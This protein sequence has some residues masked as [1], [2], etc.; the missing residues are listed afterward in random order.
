MRSGYETSFGVQHLGC[1]NCRFVALCMH[2]PGDRAASGVSLG[3]GDR[4]TSNKITV[5]PASAYAIAIVCAIVCARVRLCN[6]YLYVC[7]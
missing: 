5:Q 6:S 1:C 3:P 4:A 7:M 2:W